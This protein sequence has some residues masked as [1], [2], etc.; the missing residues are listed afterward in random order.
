[1]IIVGIGNNA[2][3]ATD[4]VPPNSCTPEGGGHAAY[5]AFIRSELIPYIELAVGG[6]PARRA[7]L[8]HSHGG[9]FV[10]YALFADAPGAHLFNAYLASD[11]SMGCMPSV[12]ESW[13]AAY[14]ASFAALPV[15]LHMS[16]TATNT[17][18]AAFAQR[19]RDRRYTQLSAHEQAYGGTH[20]G[21]IPM[22]FADAVAFAIAP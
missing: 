16:H 13:E 17:L 21:I 8:G 5:L 1:M 19:I 11:S 4:Y 3:R 20:T 9:S 18:D 14:A 10:Y 6:S 22:A 2:A 12:V 7:L 15:R